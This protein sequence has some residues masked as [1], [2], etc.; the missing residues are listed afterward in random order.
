MLEGDRWCVLDLTARRRAP[1]PGTSRASLIPPPRIGWEGWY[2]GDGIPE[3]GPLA[4]QAGGLLTAL[5]ARAPVPPEVR[6]RADERG[7]AADAVIL[8]DAD[9]RWAR[10]LHWLA[11]AGVPP[12]ARR[13]SWDGLIFPYEESGRFCSGVGPPRLSPEEPDS[14]YNRFVSALDNLCLRSAAACA[15][16]LAT[17]PG[18]RPEDRGAGCGG[19]AVRGE[20]TPLPGKRSLEFLQ[21]ASRLGAVDEGTRRNADEI[22]RKVDP[23]SRPGAF[24][25]TAADLKQCGLLAAREGRGGGYWLTAAGREAV[26]AARR[27]GGEKQ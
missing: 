12:P 3:F 19:D 14:P 22:G 8:P 21:A 24:K 27:G 2:V 9:Q 17:V 26:A 15:W 11:W 4:E 7:I 6:A 1:D 16:L 5:R 18:R 23:S 10:F 13:W 25:A 20:G